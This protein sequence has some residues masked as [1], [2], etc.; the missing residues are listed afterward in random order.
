M[1]GWK[2]TKVQKMRGWLGEGTL[3]PGRLALLADTLEDAGCSDPDWVGHSHQ[4]GPHVRGV[5][6]GGL[7]FG[8]T[9]R[10][11]QIWRSSESRRAQAAITA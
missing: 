1:T 11:L 9:V 10:W 6:D 4:P 5:L 8:E 7:T 2:K 3:E